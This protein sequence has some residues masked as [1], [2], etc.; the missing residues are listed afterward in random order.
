MKIV[1][2]DVALTALAQLRAALAVGVA[3]RRA[4]GY[5]L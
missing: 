5:K 1:G 3:R 2:A 4:D